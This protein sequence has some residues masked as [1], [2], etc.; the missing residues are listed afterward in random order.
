M[1]D[2]LNIGNKGEREAQEFLMKKG[3]VILE[4]NYE[5]EIGE[6]DIIAK[7]KE[8][9]CFIEVKTRSNLDQGDPLEAVTPE[10]MRKLYRTALGYIQECHLEDEYCRFDVIGINRAHSLSELTLIQDAFEVGAV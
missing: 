6:I 8:T 2:Y 3:Y 10:K 4:T 9:Y 1:S 7:D 5:N